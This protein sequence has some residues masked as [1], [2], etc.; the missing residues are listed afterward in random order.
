MEKNLRGYN[1]NLFKF[2]VTP[3]NE[4]TAFVGG[5]IITP[6]G[7][8]VTIERDEKHVVVF[9]R[10]INEYLGSSRDRIVASYLGVSEDSEDIETLDFY[11]AYGLLIN[12]GHVIYSG[13]GVS[14]DSKS[15][16]IILPIDYESSLTK[17]QRNS[18][19]MFLLSGK[20]EEMDDVTVCLWDSE[21]EMTV[22]DFLNSISK[23]KN[24]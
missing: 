17:E 14:N 1:N 23:S 18:C 12:L 3:K 19:V 9:N 10:Y 2:K 5:Y 15:V 11:S 22:D 16:N 20:L 6:D 24:I 7:E 13:L 21:E 8:F 4:V